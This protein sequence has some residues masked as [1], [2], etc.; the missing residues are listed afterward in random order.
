MVFGLITIISLFAMLFVPMFDVTAQT[1][2]L[3]FLH[4]ILPAIHIRTQL[5]H[6]VFHT[7]AAPAEWTFSDE[8]AGVGPVC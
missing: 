5:F 6:S 1:V 2:G 8:G 4:E 3:G 7:K